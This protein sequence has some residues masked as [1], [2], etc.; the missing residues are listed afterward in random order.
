M[1]DFDPEE[2]KVPLRIKYSKCFLVYTINPI[3]II[4]QILLVV[5]LVTKKFSILEFKSEMINEILVKLGN[6]VIDEFTSG[7]DIE[8]MVKDQLY[9]GS[10]IID[11][12]S[13]L[14]VT[15]LLQ[16]KIMDNIVN[17]YWEGPYEKEYFW[18]FSCC[19]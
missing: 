9:N 15:G 17:S 5:D 6:F 1:F 19:Y 8:I 3:K 13:Y 14:N 16:T 10:T 4:I 12:I 18:W 11:M 7:N 2:E